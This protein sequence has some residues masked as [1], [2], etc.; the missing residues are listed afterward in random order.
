[1]EREADSFAASLLYTLDDRAYHFVGQIMFDLMMTW[2]H[3]GYGT[4]T[5]TS[6][7]TSRDR[8]LA[9]FTSNPTAAS[10]AEALFGMKVDDWKALLPPEHHEEHRT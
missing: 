8:L 7:P 1:M 9:A 2:Q 5:P 4:Q 3:H 6:H 10:E